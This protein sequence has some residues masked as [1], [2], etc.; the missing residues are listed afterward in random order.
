ML[1]PP[2]ARRLRPRGSSPGREE[3][4]VKIAETGG[5]YEA[6]RAKRLGRCGGRELLG[7]WS[8]PDAVLFWR[9]PEST[10]FWA[11]KTCVLDLFATIKYFCGCW[12]STGITSRIVHSPAEGGFAQC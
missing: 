1:L 6:R 7:L 12:C 10:G 3:P 5:H 2:S 9:P 8:T 11:V 4:G